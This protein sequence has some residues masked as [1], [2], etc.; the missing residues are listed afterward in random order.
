MPLLRGPHQPRAGE[1]SSDGGQKDL[2]GPTP[3]R[4]PGIERKPKPSR[5]HPQP[6]QGPDESWSPASRPGRSQTFQANTTPALSRADLTDPP[7]ETPHAVMF[8]VKIISFLREHTQYSQGQEGRL[9]P[10]SPRAQLGHPDMEHAEPRT[11]QSARALPSTS[12]SHKA[13]KRV[14][15][16][17]PRRATQGPPSHQALPLLR[18]TDSEIRLVPFS[19]RRRLRP[20][21]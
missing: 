11:D 6:R 13:Y 9:W 17:A 4:C 10:D 8:I 3:Q 16:T 21:S 2:L 5:Q 18:L 19:Q 14:L 1:E 12:S 7:Q 15:S 20:E